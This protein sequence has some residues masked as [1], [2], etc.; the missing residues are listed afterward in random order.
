MKHVLSL[1][2]IS[3]LCACGGSGTNMP[4]PSTGGGTTGGGTTGGGTAGGG[5]TGGPATVDTASFAQ[6]LNG[7]RASN[8]AGAVTFD[9]RLAAAAQAHSDDMSRNNFFSHIGSDGSTVGDRVSAQGYTWRNVSENIA[10]GQRSEAEVMTA[11]TNSPSHHE[12]NINPV[13]EDFGLSRS[14]SA[15]G[16]PYW[17]LA[18]ATEQ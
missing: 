17:A 8:G 6:L 13:Y 7:V 9:A 4:A 2:A 1:V 18:L 3:L 15:S 12:A 11:W 10:H 16:H 5:T 14:V